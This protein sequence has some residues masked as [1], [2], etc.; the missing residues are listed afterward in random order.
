MPWP[1][2][3]CKVDHDDNIEEEGSLMK[4]VPI[5]DRDVIR[6][7]ASQ[8]VEIGSLPVQAEK[9]ELWRRLND[10]EAVS[11]WF[12]IPKGL[13]NGAGD[14]VL[15]VKPNPAIFATDT[16]NEDQARQEIASVLEQAQGYSVEL[17]MK[18][19]STVRND[20]ARL[21]CWAAIAMEEAE[22]HAG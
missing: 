22:R 4:N 1:N 16:F 19:I 21:G 14:Y 7:L 20:P 6:R 3:A 15:S 2:T 5:A 8:I 10:R 11:P 13:E 9:A 12:N 18:D 17:I